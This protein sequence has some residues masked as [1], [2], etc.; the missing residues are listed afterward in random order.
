MTVLVNE[1]FDMDAHRHCALRHM[2]KPTPCGA[3][4]VRAAQLGR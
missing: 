3:P 2:E 4:P 1:L